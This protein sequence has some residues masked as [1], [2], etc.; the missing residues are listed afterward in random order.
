[1][2]SKNCPEALDLQ[3]KHQFV[4]IHQLLL[5]GVL[6]QDVVS[7]HG[8]EMIGGILLVKVLVHAILGAQEEFHIKSFIGDGILQLEE[9]VS[10]GFARILKGDGGN[11]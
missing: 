11:M 4:K 7:G 3:V 1:M 6:K 10:Q 9:S 8:D 2:V 5:E